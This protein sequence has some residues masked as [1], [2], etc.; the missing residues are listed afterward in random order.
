MPRVAVKVVRVPKS[1]FLAYRWTD[2]LTGRVCQRSSGTAEVRK[3]ERGRARLEQQLATPQAD[4]D[5]LFSAFEQRY[6]DEWLVSLAVST[7]ITTASAFK[8][9]K[10][11]VGVRRLA[12]IS[13][14]RIMLWES[15]M[16]ASGAS[17]ATIRG[18][19]N[20][21]RGGLSWAAS[22]GLIPEV[23][24][25]TRQRKKRD[26]SIRARSRPLSDSEFARL[27]AAVPA[28]GDDEFYEPDKWR[29]YLRGLWLGGL[30]L[31]ESVTLSWDEDDPLAVDLSGRF[32]RLKILSVDKSRKDRLL[33][34]TPD[35]G[36]LLLDTPPGERR[37]AVFPL[38][39]WRGRRLGEKRVGDMVRMLGKRAGIEV[40]SQTG[41][42]AS[43][44]DLRRSFGTRWAQRVMPAV[45]KNLMRHEAI[46][47]TMKYYVAFEADE[48]AGE[49]WDK[50]SPPD[51]PAPAAPA[52]DPSQPAA[53]D[54]APVGDTLGDSG[55]KPRRKKPAQKRPQPKK[56]K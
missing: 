48:I 52:G 42:Y 13:A 53:G 18:Y 51:E 27:L 29:R 2:P 55:E 32:P 5:L 45:L 46:E 12:E 40:N 3:A 4:Q 37:G 7:R 35:F 8:S 33:P 21:F 11:L 43:A 47:T 15:R 24:W 34:L 28:D 26:A 39:G 38:V 31:W 22:V 14:D 41:K 49:L 30:R 16:R 50:F 6:A 20:H 10:K 17:E 9:F 36:Q 25:P 54:A 23:P 1:Q 56:P 19:L 44:H